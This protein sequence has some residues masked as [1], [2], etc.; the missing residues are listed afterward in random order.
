[1]ES[2]KL[3][4]GIRKRLVSGSVLLGSLGKGLAKLGNLLRGLEGGF[5]RPAQRVRLTGRPGV[6]ENGLDGVTMSLPRCS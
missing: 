4:Q 5:L 1:M 3:T 6:A 2:S